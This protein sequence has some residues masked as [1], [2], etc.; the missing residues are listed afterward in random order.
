MKSKE[1]G[2]EIKN[3]LLVNLEGM[4]KN[5]TKEAAEFQPQVSQLSI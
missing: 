5:N 2:Y 3:G 4:W 1:L